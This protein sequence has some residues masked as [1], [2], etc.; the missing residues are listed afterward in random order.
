MGCICQRNIQKLRHVTV[1]IRDERVFKQ[2]KFLGGF[3][4]RAFEWHH[5]IRQLHIFRR[6]KRIRHG[7]PSNILKGELWL[8]K[9]INSI[10]ESPLWNS[11]AVFITWDDPG[12]Y[13]DQVPRPVFHGVQLEMRLPLIVVPPMQRKIMF[14]TPS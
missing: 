12:G 11:T 6:F 10:E 1:H 8:L 7:T 3:R 5:S 13:Y 4:A 2:H 9:L 14:Q